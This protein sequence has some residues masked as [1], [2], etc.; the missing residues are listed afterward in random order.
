MLF[1]RL[2]IFDDLKCKAYATS[3]LWGLED[4][5]EAA[6]SA[7]AELEFLLNKLR[8]LSSDR[9]CSFMLFTVR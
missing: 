5:Y 9:H 2:R 6:M 1:G 8:L 4:D 3:C 7:S